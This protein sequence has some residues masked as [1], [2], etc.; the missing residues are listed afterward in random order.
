MDVLITV[1]SKSGDE[2]PANPFSDEKGDR[3]DELRKIHQHK[4]AILLN[5][6]TLVLFLIVAI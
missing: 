1:P 5:Q 2:Q 6:M 3:E 4:G